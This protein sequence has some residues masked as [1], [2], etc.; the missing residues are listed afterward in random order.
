[1]TRERAAGLLRQ[2][3][4]DT[5]VDAP[6]SGRTSAPPYRPS[7][8]YGTVRGPRLPPDDDIF[9]SHF[10]TD[11]ALEVTLEDGESSLYS[12]AHDAYYP[13]PKNSPP[14]LK[15]DDKIPIEDP[16]FRDMGL[17]QDKYTPPT[18]AEH[19]VYTPV[20]PEYVDEVP[21]L[22]QQPIDIEP[23]LTGDDI[24]DQ[25]ATLYLDYRQSVS[26]LASLVVP[27]DAVLPMMPVV[28]DPDAQAEIV[29]TK[30][31]YQLMV[32]EGTFWDTLAAG[33][34]APS[35][36]VDDFTLTRLSRTSDIMYASFERRTNPPTA[37]TYNECKEIMQA[38]GV[39]CIESSGAFEAEALASSMVL[40]G[41]ADYVV[42]EDTVCNLSASHQ[43]S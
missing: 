32:E 12:E 9:A 37:Q 27:L 41:L 43:L 20:S 38:M 23:E 16:T 17:G 26:K 5:E 14:I 24:L 18:D 34:D 30:A 33:R 25:M 39:P 8:T 13:S 21:T 35:T 10:I 7:Y 11:E 28:E 29:M 19:V 3:S 4:A 42:S 6:S 22:P 40:N 1:M 31:Q 15:F 2:L 36:A